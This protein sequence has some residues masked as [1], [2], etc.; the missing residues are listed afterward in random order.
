MDLDELPK[1]HTYSKDEHDTVFEQ[2]FQNYDE[3]LRV[4]KLQ[5]SVEEIMPVASKRD[6]NPYLYQGTPSTTTPST[7]E[8]DLQSLEKF[9]QE[10]V[11]VASVV[12]DGE[13]S[14]FGKKT[15]KVAGEVKDAV[16]NHKLVQQISK[17]MFN[18]MVSSKQGEQNKQDKPLMKADDYLA[19]Y[20]NATIPDELDQNLKGNGEDEEEENPFSFL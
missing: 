5:E 20:P 14:N 10:D 3:P 16:I 8:P 19:E 4:P 11:Q 2:S 1:E 12:K 18:F 13:D 7:E 6:S 17:G 9:D 15:V